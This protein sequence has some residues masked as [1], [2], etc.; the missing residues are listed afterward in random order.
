MDTMNTK[1]AV[2]QFRPSPLLDKALDKNLLTHL[3]IMKQAGQCGA[4]LLV[5]PEMSLSGYELERV[6]TNV[7]IYAL[8]QALEQ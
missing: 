1:I 6:N 4:T 7:L 3:S 2:A 8:M 5:F